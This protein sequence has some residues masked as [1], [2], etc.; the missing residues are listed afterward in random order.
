[1]CTT[2]S[3]LDRTVAQNSAEIHWAGFGTSEN[4]LTHVKA[5]VT[6]EPARTLRSTEKALVDLY[7][8]FNDILEEQRNDRMT[9]SP[10]LLTH[11]EQELGIYFVVNFVKG[12]RL[13]G[14]LLV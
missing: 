12:G 8:K 1:M 2:H 3:A 4:C 7:Q 5:V 14:Y 10:Y 13:P 11:L 9:K 6:A